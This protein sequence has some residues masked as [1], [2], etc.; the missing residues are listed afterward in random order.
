MPVHPKGFK[1]SLTQSHHLFG[2]V[3]ESGIDH[4]LDVFFTARPH[5]LAYGT[6]Y[7]AS[8]QNLVTLVDTSSRPLFLSGLECLVKLDIPKV[9]IS[10]PNSVTELLPPGSNQFTIFTD[11]ALRFR[12]GNPKYPFIG[13][14]GD[15]HETDI[16]FNLAALCAPHVVDSTPGSGSIGISLV[17]LEIVGI[18]PVGLER[19]LECILT[20]A[21]RWALVQVIIQF[22]VFTLDGISLMLQ[23]GP[24][25]TDNQIEIRGDI[26]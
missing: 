8:N 12:C 26:S 11:V 17:K 4:F 10:P 2:G 15:T 13:S 20:A 6:P 16:K 1:M 5:L 14:N 25:A 24:L 3:S 23:Q 22:N 19:I 18:T 7:Y 21:L 9:D